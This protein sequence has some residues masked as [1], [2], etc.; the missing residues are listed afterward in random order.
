MRPPAPEPEEELRLNLTPMVDCVFLLIIFFL[1]TTAFIKLEQD[2]TI[3]LPVQ[4]RELKVRTPPARPIVVNVQ[5]RPGGRAYY[6]VE[7]EPM[8]L[9]ALTVNLSRARIHNPDQAVVIRGDRNVKWEH[10]A[11]V[12]GC[13]AQAGIIKVSATVEIREKG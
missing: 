10:I 3:N 6:H 7:N 1:V 2:L 9:P 4:S 13:C 12:M 8:S 5:H 11:A